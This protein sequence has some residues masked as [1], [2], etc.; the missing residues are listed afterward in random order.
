MLK[1]KDIYQ[2]ITKNPIIVNENESIKDIIIKVNKGNPALSCVYVTDQENKLTGTIS[3]TALLNVIAVRKG[4]PSHRDLSVPELFRYT[5][6]N[7]VAKDI[8][9]KP[10]VMKLDERL[11]DAIA[12]LIKSDTDGVAIVDDNMEIIGDLNIY[13]VLCSIPYI[14]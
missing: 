7:M 1:I 6:K 3:L 14:E 4:I 8:M 2:L 13:E 5:G 12:A 11:E 9:A 10:M